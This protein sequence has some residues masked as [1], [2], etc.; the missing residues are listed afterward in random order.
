MDVVH[1]KLGILA[2]SKFTSRPYRDLYR[3]ET[4]SS[5]YTQSS[6]SSGT[7][8]QPSDVSLAVA[9]GDTG[10]T[11]SVDSGGGSS[12]LA[13]Q[14]TN[15]A[16]TETKTNPGAA[17]PFAMSSSQDSD[18]DWD[19]T[20]T[21]RTR[22][23]RS[24]TVSAE[25]YRKVLECVDP[26]AHPGKDILEGQ[27]KAR[28]LNDRVPQV[29]KGPDEASTSHVEP[30]KILQPVARSL[31]CSQGADSLSGAHLISLAPGTRPGSSVEVGVAGPRAGTDL[32][33]LGEHD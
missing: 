27:T 4:V 13:E 25:L 17:G 12:A 22:I 30:Q 24:M 19:A 2:I 9:F 16:E 6:Q 14:D 21:I 33:R 28:Q 3:T 23:T 20:N 7:S 31:R 18:F 10:L 1:C 26:A 5:D 15:A 32:R 11:P 8:S 29:E